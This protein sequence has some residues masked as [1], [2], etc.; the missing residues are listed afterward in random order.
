MPNDIR[1]NRNPNSDKNESIS[2]DTGG[3]GS[4]I[5]AD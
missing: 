5:L 3:G 1:L 2:S 4:S